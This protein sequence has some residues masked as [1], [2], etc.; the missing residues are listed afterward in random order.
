MTKPI[1][2]DNPRENRICFGPMNVVSQKRNPPIPERT[3]VNK[4][5]GIRNRR[6]D[7]KSYFKSFFN[8]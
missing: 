6:I 1:M 5:S 8:I 2:E 3:G 7:R 4:S